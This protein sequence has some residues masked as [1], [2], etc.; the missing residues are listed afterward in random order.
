MIFYSKNIIKK[1]VAEATIK[2]T[3]LSAKV[4]S[5]KLDLNDDQENELIFKELTKSELKNT[6]EDFYA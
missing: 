1:H 5:L 2:L 4:Q 6:W 3:I